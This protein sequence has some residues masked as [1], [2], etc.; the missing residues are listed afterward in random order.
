MTW[1]NISEPICDG[2]KTKV[3]YPVSCSLVLHQSRHQPELLT[4]WSP[5]MTELQ[6]NKSLVA[7]LQDQIHIMTIIHFMLTT[8]TGIIIVQPLRVLSRSVVYLGLVLCQL[9]LSKTGEKK[10][11]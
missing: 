3:K 9:H 5:T 2:V 11:F 4:L 8:P 6:T 1:L 7:H 10:Y